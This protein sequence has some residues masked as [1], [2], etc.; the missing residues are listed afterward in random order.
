MFRGVGRHQQFS[1]PQIVLLI[2]S[3]DNVIKKRQAS[4][5]NKSGIAYRLL[6][7]NGLMLGAYTIQPSCIV[8]ALLH[9]VE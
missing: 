1:C 6:N 4:L 9:D 7:G 8:Q 5:V 3:E 2:S